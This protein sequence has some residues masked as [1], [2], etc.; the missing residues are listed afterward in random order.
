[1]MLS[2]TFAKTIISFVSSKVDLKEFVRLSELPYTFCVVDGHHSIV[3]ISNTLSERFIVA[4]SIDDRG[5]AEKLTDFHNE[6][7][8]AGEFD[9]VLNRLNSLVPN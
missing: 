3:D 5:V 1:M 2:L 6:L 7:W 4:L 9:S 8:E